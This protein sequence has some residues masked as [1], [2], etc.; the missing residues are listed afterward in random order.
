MKTI[1]VPT[2]FSPV[3]VNAMN[4]ALNLARHIEARVILFHAYQVPVAFSEVPVVTI[5]MEEMK[6]QTDERMEELRKSVEHVT[7][8]ELDVSTRNVLGDTSEELENIARELNPF[9]IVMGTRGAGAVETILMGSTTLTAVNRLHVPVMI[10]PP[11]ASYRPIKTIGFACDYSRV[12]ED[13]PIQQVTKICS[14]FGAKLKVLNVDYD[15]RH[16][17]ADVPAG[18]ARVKELLNPLN[19]DYYFLDDPDV[20]NAI[21][22]FAETHGIDLL[23]TIPK[24]HRFLEGLFK[25]SHTRELAVHAHVPLLAIHG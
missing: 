23:I 18:M 12:A 4:Y 2:D 22:A 15:N 6:R 16:F 9:A 11:G 10:I 8:G 3:S 24:K 1:I 25:K 14:M 17:T 7:S 13:A 21:N 19:P 5:S 20:D